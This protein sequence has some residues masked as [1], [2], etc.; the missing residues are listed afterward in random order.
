MHK[1]GVQ[2][3]ALYMLFYFFKVGMSSTERQE[4]NAGLFDALPKRTH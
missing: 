3:L 4:V 1:L 2:I